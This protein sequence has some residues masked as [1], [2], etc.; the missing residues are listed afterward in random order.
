VIFIGAAAV[1]DFSPSNVS[2]QKIKK[3]TT[4]GLTLELKLNQDILSIVAQSS[5]AEYVVG[6]AAETTDLIKHAMNKLDKKRVDMIVANLVGPKR[7]FDEDVNEV[8]ILTKHSQ[9]QLPLMH[10]TRLAGQMIA[11][12]ARNLQNALHKKV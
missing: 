7:G 3:D 10:K 1:A 6:F 2:Q 12:L 11:I 8:V 9:E 4:E 5:K